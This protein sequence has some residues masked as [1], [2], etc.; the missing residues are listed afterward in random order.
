MADTYL[1]IADAG[2]SLSLQRRVAACA[3]QQAVAGDPYQWAVTNRLGWASAPGWGAA[4]ASAVAGGVPDPGADPAVITD[5]MILSQV[6]SM[7]PAGDE[8]SPEGG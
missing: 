5:A 1:D 4:W 8:S 6:Q 7:V 2:D 3:A